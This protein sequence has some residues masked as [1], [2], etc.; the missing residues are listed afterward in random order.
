MKRLFFLLSLCVS[1]SL[2]WANQ[3]ITGKVVSASNGEPIIGAAVVVA[4]T[5]NGTV[6]D[7]DGVFTLDVAQD[8]KLVVSFLG[9]TT[10]EVT[11]SNNLVVRLKET[12]HSIDE[13]MVVGFGT[14]TK[15]SYTGSASVVKAE[16]IEKR[17]VSNVTQALAGSVAGVVGVS[18]SGQ[19]GTLAT[20]QIRGVGS[21]H[22]STTPLY[23]VDGIP[24]TTDA[25][26]LLNNSDIESVNILKDATS[27][28]LYGARGANGV[29]V[30]TTKRG[31]TE[32][33][34]ISVNAKWGT[35][36][37]GIPNYNVMT[38]PAMYYETFYKSLYMGQV[39]NN[40]ATDAAATAYA[41]KNL[42][43]A[44]NG[45]LGYQVY[46][47]PN[48]E[49]LIGTNGK[50]NP[51]AQL[52]Y[53]N[54]NG[55]LLTPDS[56]YNELFQTNNF[57][58]EYNL[59]ISGATD[60]LN[61]VVT[62]SYL[63]DKGIIENSFFNR[64][65]ARSK[66][67]YKAT[68]WLKVG[69]NMSFSH[70]DMHYPQEDEYGAYSSANIFYLSNMM[71]PIYPLYIRNADG[72]IAKDANGYTMYDYGDGAAVAPG[73]EMPIGAQRPFMSQ[74]NPGSQIQL[75]Q[76]GNKIDA[77][78]GNWFVEV[79][80]YK[81]LKGFANVGV[82]YHGNRYN[83]TVNPFYGQY[84]SRGGYAYVQQGR[85][86]NLEQVYM[87]TYNNVFAGKH[88][89]DLM[90]GYEN[91]WQ[92]SSS[93]SG[94]K[95]K[96]YNPDIAEINNAILDPSTSS[97]SSDYKLQSIKAH[98]AYSYDN[99][100]FVTAN[101]AREAS[102]RFAP[103]KRWGNFWAVGL[104]WD[105][106]GEHFM[107]KA[108]V[109]DQLKLK[110]SYGALGNDGIGS[111]YAYTDQYT[112]SNNNGSFATTLVYKGNPDITWETTYN[113]NGG[114]DFAF[115]GERLSG[116]IEGYRRRTVDMLYNQPVPSSLGYSTIPVNVG[117]VSNA[118]LD[119][120]LH[121]DLIRTKNVCWTAYF[122]LSYNKSKILSLAPE[123]NGELIDGTTIYKE[124]ESMYNRYLKHY[125][126]VEKETGKPM[127]L[128]DVYDEE[129]NVTGTETT[130]DYS[131][132]TSY[133]SGNVKAPVYGGFGTN[134]TAYGVDLGIA[135]RY[136]AGGKAYDTNYKNLMHGG[137]EPGQNWSVDILKAWTPENT[138]TDVPALNSLDSYVNGTSDRWL[139][140]SNYVS[141]DNITLGY[142]FP[143]Q[144]LEKIKLSKLRV[145]AVADNITV[146][147]ARKGFDPRQSTTGGLNT[148]NYTPIRA[149]S[150]GIQVDF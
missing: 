72:S 105:I 82:N 99:R 113:F 66:V 111:L 103:D 40:G 112:I 129:G 21:I 49:R 77:F 28:S 132:A 114:V 128:K 65:T 48:G 118:G 11:A 102:S 36:Q 31:K 142:T 59:N 95:N 37:R 9:M 106:A 38:D 2:V 133:A 145:Y 85:D 140:S 136:Q 78:D 53:V 54:G 149:I 58:H 131:A 1:V 69:A 75:D 127:W 5:T 120:E 62:A 26:A 52:G 60:K 14:T 104:G 121:G 134:L 34:H 123:L 96:L 70:A 86:F 92:L 64:V 29:V 124:G 17:Q 67:E 97:S 138:D 61:Y 73:C 32:K 84:A 90:V 148:L 147:S 116:T 125:A 12:S 137:S 18:S 41:N 19:P 76:E 39:I 22:A 45:G 87:L 23:V 115:F 146:F 74:S 6:T 107:D 20:I 15:K 47:L 94:Q 101:Y 56:W 30:I 55:Y 79:E 110:A 122:N 126:G 119:L 33:T 7:L 35:N 143:K 91:E 27:A 16:D 117:S 71:A 83:S 42:L 109:V 51:N 50:L 130:T 88:N 81:G 100:Y 46:T 13:V 24:T 57:R 44:D 141:L 135:F 43:N 108:T 93:L 4:G 80:F 68:K 3:T 25:V 63:G 150:A 139:I 98:A 10:M 89:V 8:A 144:W